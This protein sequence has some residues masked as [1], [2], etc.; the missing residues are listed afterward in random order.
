MFQRSRPELNGAETLRKVIVDVDP[1]LLG[2]CILKGHRAGQYAGAQPLSVLAWLSNE[3]P[4]GIGFGE[5]GIRRE[6]LAVIGDTIH[7]ILD[8]VD[9]HVFGKTEPPHGR[10]TEPR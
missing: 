10:A 5:R 4:I 9:T 6:F 3:P 7:A 1:K 2:V 8:G